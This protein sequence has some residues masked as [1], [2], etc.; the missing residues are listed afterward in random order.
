MPTQILAAIERNRRRIWAICYR[1]TGLRT[2]A[3][4]LAQ[5]AAARAIERG[6]Q[7]TEEDPTGWLLRLTTRLCIDHLRHKKIERRLT[8]L[9]DPLDGHDWPAG[10][11]E[12]RAPEGAAALREDIRFAVVVALQRLSPRQRAALILHDICDR[13]LEETAEALG[14]NANATKALLHRARAALAKARHHVDTDVPVDRDVVERFAQAIEAGSIEAL[15]DLLA[16][17]VWGITDGGGII[18]TST[19][20]NF[21]QRAVSRQWANAKRR[22]DQPVTTSL[23]TINGEPAIV[24]RLAGMPDVVVAVVHVETRRG[25]VA[26][27]RVNRDP[28]KIGY[29]TH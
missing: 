4:D 2:D 8:E 21:G 26:A 18:A 11:L 7:A 29:V 13:S 6:D 12:A 10:D 27:L 25:H 19:K 16:G 1:M 15:T 20:P 14:T 17:D 24:I 23:I 9:V 3:D 22:L 5:E 28:R